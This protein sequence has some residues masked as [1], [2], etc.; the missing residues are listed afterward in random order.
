MIGN[1]SKP[2][3]AKFAGIEIYAPGCKGGWSLPGEGEGSDGGFGGPGDRGD[4]VRM[5]AGAG[6]KAISMTLSM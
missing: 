4:W 2:E 3:D 6:I 1:I 5:A